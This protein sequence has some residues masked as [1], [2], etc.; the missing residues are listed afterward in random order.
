MKLG[1]AELAV[2]DAVDPG[3][4]LLSDDLRDR[5]PDAPGQQT[6]LERVKPKRVLSGQPER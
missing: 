1:V 2:V 4:D 3:L 5:A 6:R